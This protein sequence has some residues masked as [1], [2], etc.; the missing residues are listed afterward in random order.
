MSEANIDVGVTTVREGAPA[1]ASSALASGG[2][3]GVVVE[4][5]LPKRPRLPFREIVGSCHDLAWRTLRRLGVPAANV[6]DALQKVFLAVHAHYEQLEGG[7]ERAY[8]LSVCQGVAANERRSARRKDA[9]LG[10]LAHEPRGSERSLEVVLDRAKARI[11]L[12]QVL[13]DLDDD[14]RFVFVLH[15]FEELSGPEIATSVG[16]PVGTVASRLRRARERV[17][18]GLERLRLRE[19]GAGGVP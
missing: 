17:M 1:N 19:L 3:A 16:V 8:V 7:A 12:E 11:M 4:E 13:D 9:A 10:A 5:A 14:L 18:L 15:E 6:D 2:M